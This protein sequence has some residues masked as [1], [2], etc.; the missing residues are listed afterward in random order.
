MNRTFAQNELLY[1]FKSEFAPNLH[2]QYDFRF[3]YVF[4][5]VNQMYY[6]I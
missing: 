2:S 1:N 3:E 4:I 5:Y 6:Q